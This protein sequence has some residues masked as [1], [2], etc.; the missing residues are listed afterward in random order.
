M[1]RRSFRIAGIAAAGLLGWADGA[2]AVDGVIEI[3]DASIVAASGYPGVIGASGSY[4]LTSNL[5]PPAGV[6]GISVDAHDVTLDLNGFEI[7]GGG[8]AVMGDR[9]RARGRDG[10]QWQ[11]QRLHGPPGSSAGGSSKIFEVHVSLITGPGIGGVGCLIVESTIRE[12]RATGIQADG[13]KIE[14]N[15][16]RSGNDGPASA[17]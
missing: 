10:A 12:G 8:A 1:K 5:A 9:R 16:D 13:C 15:I 6:D 17:A 11:R 2:R 4:V 14:N 3:N 7:N